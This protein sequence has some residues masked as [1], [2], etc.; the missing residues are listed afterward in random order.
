LALTLALQAIGFGQPK[1]EQKQVIQIHQ[2][3]VISF[4][5]PPKP[6]ELENGEGHS[7]AYN[8]F[9]YYVNLAEE[10]L[11]RSGIEIRSV[12]AREFA[13]RDGNRIRTIKAGKGG[14]GDCMVAPGKVPRMEFGVMIDQD[15]FDAVR[16][17]FGIAIQ[18]KNEKIAATRSE[19]LPGAPVR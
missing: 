18:Q 7:E 16:K 19:L 3:T 10:P 9:A 11:S 5:P 2:A 8:D 15:L 14:F 12:L 4:E 13:V 6:G 17:Y 1:H